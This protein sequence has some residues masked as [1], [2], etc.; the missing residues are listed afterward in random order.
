MRG[1]FSYEL[2]SGETKEVFI[3]EDHSTLEGLAKLINN[4]EDLNLD[5]ITFVSIEL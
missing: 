4:E 3:D 5:D 2:P 1:F